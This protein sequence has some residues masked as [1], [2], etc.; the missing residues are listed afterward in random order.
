[1]CHISKKYGKERFSYI[2]IAQKVID[3]LK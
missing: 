3:D 2:N 1:L